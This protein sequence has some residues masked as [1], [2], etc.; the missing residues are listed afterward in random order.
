M[1]AKTSKLERAEAQGRRDQAVGRKLADNPFNPD[2]QR[3]Q[4][5]VYAVSWLDSLLAESSEK[6]KERERTL[7]AEGRL[8]GVHV[9]GA[10]R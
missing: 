4:H 10:L 2:A 9:S 5:T 3:E 8:A 1:N 7:A 6:E